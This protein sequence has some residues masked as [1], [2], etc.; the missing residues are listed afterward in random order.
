MDGCL[1]AGQAGMHACMGLA[2]LCGVHQAGGGGGGKGAR[3]SHDGHGSVPGAWAGQLQVATY[4]CPLTDALHA[5]G[6]PLEA[7]GPVGG[8]V[9]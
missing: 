2:G 7:G 9:G 1:R 6:Q 5:Q 3:L 8:P 4:V